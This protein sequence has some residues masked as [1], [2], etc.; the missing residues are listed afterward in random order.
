MS[1]T[2]DCKNDYKGDNTT[3][4]ILRTTGD[5]P[6]VI[7]G[8]RPSTANEYVSDNTVDKMI[9]YST[10]KHH[11]IKFDGIIMLNLYPLRTKDSISLL[12]I[13]DTLSDIDKNK[14]IQ[15]NVEHIKN[16]LNRLS[17]EMDKIIILA[18]WGKPETK[19]QER[20]FAKCLREILK[21]TNK[22][23]EWKMSKETADGHPHSFRMGHEWRLKEF[24][25][26]EYLD[27]IS[28]A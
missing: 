14:L 1:Y 5:K 13:V 26:Q 11:P 16:L 28:Q 10:M 3:R 7:I 21:A 23:C 12:P 17:V 2:G 22:K 15:Q 19:T 4:F 18:A 20:F 9:T 8:F 27:L 6:L 24:K 25:V